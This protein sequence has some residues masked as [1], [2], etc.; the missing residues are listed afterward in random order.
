MTLTPHWLISVVA[1]GL[2]GIDL[3]RGIV[4]TVLM[5]SVAATKAGLDFTS[6][7]GPEQAVIMQAFGA[8]NFITGAALILAAL[9]AR[10]VALGL[11]T[12]IPLAY[13]TAGVSLEAWIGGLD[14]TSG[15]WDGVQLMSV[16][17]PVAAATAAFGW[18]QV[19]RGSRV[20]EASQAE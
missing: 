7:G 8:S 6:A 4:H 3:I 12:V 1:L 11:L 14:A 17:L 13:A 20:E 10:P 5:G 19:W 16:Y 9:Y 15:R 18:W 2:G